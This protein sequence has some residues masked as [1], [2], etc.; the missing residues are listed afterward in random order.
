MS[1]LFMRLCELRD[2]YFNEINDYDLGRFH[3]LLVCGR[4]YSS[5]ELIDKLAKFSDLFELRGK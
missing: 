4:E 5:D 1:K 2:E 3:D